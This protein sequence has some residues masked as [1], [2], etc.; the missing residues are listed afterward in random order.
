MLHSMGK[1]LKVHIRF[2]SL[3]TQVHIFSLVQCFRVEL[4][5]E[6][7]TRLLPALLPKKNFAPAKRSS[8]LHERV[9][10]FIELVSDRK[11]LKGKNDCA[12]ATFRSWKTEHLCS[13]LN[14]STFTAMS[15]CGNAFG[16]LGPNKIECYITLAWKGLLRK[17]SS[18]SGPNKLESHCRGT[19][20]GRNLRMFVMSSGVGPYQP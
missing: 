12:A 13:C 17:H 18:L 20:Y 3:L 15:V 6:W 1:Y 7:S 19:F 8:L 10:V 2:K 16:L 9:T 4:P 14:S 11:Q 5:L